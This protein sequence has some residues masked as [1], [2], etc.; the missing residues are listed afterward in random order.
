MGMAM[1]EPSL[2]L[3]MWDSMG[4][5]EWQQGIAF[6][7]CSISYLIG[8]NVFGPI[9]HKIGRW[10]SGGIGM[11]IISVSLFCIPF[12]KTIMHLLAPN[13]CLGFAIGITLFISK[14]DISYICDLI[15]VVFDLTY[16]MYVHIYVYRLH[17]RYG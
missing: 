8:T 15:Q 9:S 13:F 17:Y 12:A 10:R 2:P 6:L 4:A 16:I 11:F 7:L 3:W 1:L 14:V 5:Q